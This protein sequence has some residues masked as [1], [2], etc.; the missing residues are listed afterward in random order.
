M[1]HSKKLVIIA[2][3]MFSVCKSSAQV[4]FGMSSLYD[5]TTAGMLLEAQRSYLNTMREMAIYRNQLMPIIVDTYKAAYNKYSNG[6]YYDCAVIISDFL[7]KYTI[8]KG[9]GNICCNLYE[10]YGMSLIKLNDYSNGLSLLRKAMDQG[11]SSA[12]QELV[13]ICHKNSLEAQR[14]FDK[15]DYPSSLSYINKALAT[16]IG[17]PTDLYELKG[18]AH[19][20]M[21]ERSTG[22]TLLQRAM[23]QGSSRA[24]QELEK[25]FQD[26]YSKAYRCFIS[27]E[28]SSSLLHINNTFTTGLESSSVYILRGDVYTKLH[29]FDEAKKNYR[30]AEKMG[31]ALVPDRLKQLKQ[32]KKEYKNNK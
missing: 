25:I 1:K 24:R 6:N 30:I 2:I 18:M 9:L 20:K 15:G 31:S 5:P 23:N 19:L 8:Y 13:N 4:E 21:G 10:L 14:C 12:Q 28:Y 17:N 3:F 26:D 11:S 27:G 29:Q 22:I 7:N 16:C 32:A